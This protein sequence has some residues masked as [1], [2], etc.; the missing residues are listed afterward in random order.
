MTEQRTFSGDSLR[1]VMVHS[2][3][4]DEIDTKALL[5]MINGLAKGASASVA[6]LNEVETQLAARDE[7][8]VK[9]ETDLEAERQRVA[10]LQEKVNAP[11]GGRE[12]PERALSE[13]KIARTFGEDTS[14]KALNAFLSHFKL[15]K[16]QNNKRGVVLWE[17]ESYRAGALRLVLTDEVAEFVDTEDSMGSSWVND[18]AMIVQRLK[19]RYLKAECIELNILAFEEAKQLDGESLAAFMTRLQSLVKNA[20]PS[21]P[22]PIMRQRVV[23]RFLTGVRDADIKK[24]LI[25]SKWMASQDEPKPY[26]EILKAAESILM[27]KVAS[28]SLAGRGNQRQFA[29]V[30]GVSG[31]HEDRRSAKEQSVSRGQEDRRAAKEQSALRPTGSKRKANVAAA[32]GHGEAGRQNSSNKQGKGYVMKCYYC[33][34]FHEGGWRSCDRMKKNE[35]NWK[36]DF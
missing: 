29:A 4:E 18:D 26:S 30:A 16:D 32:S 7:A 11:P 5:K 3:S 31:G 23:W 12:G 33:R 22:E 35:P 9:V 14:P 21:N 2:D 15:V 28:Q 17:D 13:V 20:F 34:E 8:L 1:F 6:R 27:T 36:P 24:G 19:E 25:S 10:T